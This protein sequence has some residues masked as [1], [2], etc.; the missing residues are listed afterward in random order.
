[1]R[2]LNRKLWRDIWHFRSQLSAIVA[3]VAS[4]IALFVALR[5]MHGFLRES[6]AAFYDR[7]RFADVFAPLKRA[8][9]SVAR[10]VAEIPGV[11]DVSARVVHEVTLDVPGLAEPAIGRLVAIP[12]PRAAS[13]NELHLTAGRWPDP[14]R[15]LEVIASSAFAHA[16]ALQPGDTLGAVVNGRWEQLRIVGTG[17]SPEYVYEI[18]GAALFPDNRRFG[19]LWMGQDAL[20]DAFDMRGAF[21]DL[22]LRLLPNASLAAVIERVDTHLRPYGGFGAYGRASQMSHQ[23]VAGEIDETQATSILLP[24]IFLGVTAF[25]LNMVLTRL[26]GTQREQIATLKAFGYRDASIANHYLA[27]AVVPV[28]VGS[29]VGAALGLWLATKLAVVYT[30]YFQFP[31]TTFVPDWSIV[32]AAM[33]IGIGSGALGAWSAV[34][35]TIALRPAESMR[36]EAPP[37]YRPG[38]LERFAWFRRVPPAA[39]IIARNLARRPTKALLSVFGISLALSIV[40]TTLSIFDVVDM[41]KRLQFHAISRADVT[42]MF[43]SPR[44]PLAAQSLL[45]LPGVS[46]VESFHGVPV[47]L[48]AGRRT[49]RSVI[50]GLPPD[51]QLHRIVDRSWNVHRA[52]PNGMIFSYILAD[53]LGVKAGDSVR[54]EVME[55]RR[56]TRTTVVA[57]VVDDLFG[58]T[59]FMSS[60]ALRLLVDEDAITGAWLEVDA[61]L[62]DTVY[63]RLKRIPAVSGVSVRDA[64]LR[65]FEKTIAESFNISL[66]TTMAFACVIA[67][68]VV[69]NGARVALSERGRELAS[70]RVLGFTQREVAAMLLGEQGLLMI[71]ALPV[72]LAVTY[73]LCALLSARFD[74]ELFRIPVMVTASSFL[75]GVAVVAISGALS[76][77]AVRGRLTRLDL[78]GV[79]KTRE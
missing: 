79:L 57:G 29:V 7:Y 78:V 72:G 49:Y 73:I 5:S 46:A 31:A 34:R 32:A 19:I 15:P 77:L 35:R 53:V 13:L 69:Y 60:D 17:I 42:V 64:E 11:R 76:A 38:L 22:T 47:R 75:V 41:M 67:F 48:R 66:Y 68:S 16:N 10:E 2:A 56:P 58:A 26:V 43:D 30:R 1:M 4:G 18:S 33:I 44:P 52:P 24:A 45:Q 8:P 59:A 21:N 36:P 40:V 6:Q 65:G 14:S 23:Y 27:L 71:L 74:S 51:A 70:L 54:V 63:A 50:I 37:R 25:L 28:G 55:G 20:A 12:V 61:R 39:H 62:R 3:V 9:V